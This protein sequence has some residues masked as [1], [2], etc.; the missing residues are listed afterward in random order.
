MGHFP[1]EKQ[2]IKSL[3]AVSPIL[4]MSIKISVFRFF[5]FCVFECFLSTSLQNCWKRI[6]LYFFYRLAFLL[7]FSAMRKSKKYGLPNI[8]QTNEKAVKVV[9][10][11]RNKWKIIAHSMIFQIYD[12]LPPL[13]AKASTVRYG[14]GKAEA[15]NLKVEN[16]LPT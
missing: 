16:R 4:E 5:Q 13:V 8:R 7:T 12:L 10:A 11:V 15:R 9:K 2:A 1:V 3:S 14:A 6:F